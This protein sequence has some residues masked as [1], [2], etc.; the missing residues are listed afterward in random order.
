MGGVAHIAETQ[1]QPDLQRDA[2]EIWR[3]V[4]RLVDRAPSLADLRSHKLEL[5]AVR[6]WRALGRFIPAEMLDRERRAALGALAAPR[7]LERVRT[8]YG[9]EIIPLKGLEVAARYP[10]P[11]LRSFGDLDLLAA[12]AEAAQ[13]A[14]LGA[15]FVE[16]GNPAIY[17]G[18]H[19]LRPLCWPGL[20]L[21]V[22]I[23]S[24]PKWPGG[25]QPPPSTRELFDA[26]AGDQVKTLPAAQHALLLAAHSWA[27]EPLRRLRDMV[28]V[29]VMAEAAGRAEVAALAREWRI[30]RLWRSTID[31][32]DAVLLGNDRPLALR[33]WAQNLEKARERTVLE[34]H[35]Q[36]WVSDFWIMR[37]GAAA[38]RVP[39]TIARELLP[40]ESEGWGS[41]LSRTTRAVRNASRRRSEHNNELD[42]RRRR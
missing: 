1:P 4:D 35:L 26:A 42:L 36:R 39:T 13:A 10:D 32:A 38:A 18:I 29:A 40:K 41:K 16:V 11:A 2:A 33:L 30:E 37:F 15:G 14:L 24:R 28:D 3:A 20:P 34:N 19:H 6:R 25:I 12:D 9:G 7:L 21:V 5:F 27:H 22:E 8:A 17:L 23:H 31:A